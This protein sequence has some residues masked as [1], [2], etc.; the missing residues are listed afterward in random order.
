[1]VAPGRTGKFVP[2]SYE[3]AVSGGKLPKAGFFLWTGAQALPKEKF[4]TGSAS[5]RQNLKK[6]WRDSRKRFL[7]VDQYGASAKVLSAW[8][9]IRWFKF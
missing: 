9:S 4:T 6:R 8:S 5:R 2:Q 7:E 3:E 1:L